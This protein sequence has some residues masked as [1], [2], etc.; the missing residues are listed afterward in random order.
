[1]YTKFQPFL[2]TYKN[3]VLFHRDLPIVFGDKKHGD[4][5]SAVNLLRKKHMCAKF[6]AILTTSKNSELSHRDLPIVF[7][8][9]KNMVI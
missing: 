7:G 3:S 2:T 8:D 6:Q 1:M 9:K 4:L 5:S